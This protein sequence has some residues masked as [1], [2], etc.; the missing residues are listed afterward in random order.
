MRATIRPAGLAIASM[1]EWLEGK[2]RTCPKRLDAKRPRAIGRAALLVGLVLQLGSAGRANGNALRPFDQLDTNEAGH[3]PRNAYLMSLVSHYAYP[4]AYSPRAENWAVFKNK[5]VPLM[6][7]WGMKQVVPN[8][9]QNVQY[10]VMSNDRAVIVVFRGSDHPYG[11]DGFDDWVA[12]NALATLKEVPLWG[13]VSYEERNALGQTKTVSHTPKVH[14]GYYLKYVNLRGSLNAQLARHGAGSKALFFTGHSL[15]GAFA[16][17]AAI[18]QG[19]GAW[20]PQSRYKARGVYTFGAPRVGNSVFAD[21]YK[22]QQSAAG[23]PA[24]NTSRYYV[25]N[26]PVPQLPPN[27]LTGQKDDWY[28][29]QV[30]YR[31]EQ[32]GAIVSGA[33]IVEVE[34]VTAAHWSKWYVCRLHSAYIASNRKLKL[35]LPDVPGEPTTVTCDRAE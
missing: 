9:E 28:H 35:T 8:E 12:T 19:S 27:I 22:S 31:I 18:D 30:A 7:T 33:P 10:V 26:D 15:G 24:L 14:A 13:R 34:P 2:D 5:F 4:H 3:S 1:T 21:L 23:T 32:G 29:V 6:T 20:P 11:Q 25:Y 16:T 17:L